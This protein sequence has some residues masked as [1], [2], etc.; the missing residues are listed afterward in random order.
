MWM[1]LVKLQHK[2]SKFHKNEFTTLST[3]K[4]CIIPN[5]IVSKK[6]SFLIE[7]ILLLFTLT[8]SIN[9]IIHV[10]DDLYYDGKGSRNML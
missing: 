8:N 6:L 3:K 2:I 9:F 10:L 5:H 7:R 1:H 4:L